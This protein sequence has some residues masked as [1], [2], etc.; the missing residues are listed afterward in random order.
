MHGDGRYRVGWMSWLAVGVLAVGALLAG[1][2]HAGIKLPVETCSTSAG[3]SGC[4]VC[5]NGVCSF[6]AVGPVCRCDAECQLYGE[7]SCSLQRPDQPRCGG[8]C[9][10]AASTALECGGAHD[11]WTIE[12]AAAPSVS[13]EPPK[14][15]V[16][17]S[18]YPTRASTHL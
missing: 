15:G 8:H 7:G 13:R 9:V 16:A 2:A 6:E 1:T 3:C 12:P 17:P 10:A 4:G 11:D 18:G 5:V 14:S